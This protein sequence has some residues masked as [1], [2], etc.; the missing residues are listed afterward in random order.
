MPQEDSATKDE[1]KREVADRKKRDV[2]ARKNDVAARKKNV[3]TMFNA[4]AR[5]YDLLNHLLSAGIDVYWRRRALSRYRGQAPARVLD[6]ATGTGDFALAARRLSPGRIIGTDVAIEMVRLG[7]PKVAQVATPE[8]LRLLGGDAE[9]LP[10]KDDC[11][12]LITVAF[13]VRNFGDIPTGLAEAARVLRPG[14]ELIVLDF[15][16]PTLPGFRQLYQFYFKHI[17]PTLG[18]WI[19]GNRA[20]YSYLPRSVGTFPQGDA[21]LQLLQEAG[22][23]NNQGLSMSLGICAVYQGL[24]Q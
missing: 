10:F 20:A 3:Q 22:F 13:G 5:R 12:D 16:E 17:L 23:H 18:G 15:T 1:R 21:F 11:F 8:S 4:I 19:S 7:V 6:L 24:K 9:L 2:A 14:G